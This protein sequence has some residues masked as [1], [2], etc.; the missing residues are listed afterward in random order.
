LRADL[1]RAWMIA[2]NGHKPYACGVVLH[3]A[4]DAMLDLRAQLAG[5]VDAI[6]RIEVQ[7]NPSVVAITGT[8]APTTG[9]HSKFSIYHS[10][11]VALVDG[12]A[13][14]AQYTDARAS[15]PRVTALRDRITVSVDESLQR[16]QANAQAWV[17]GRKLEARVAHASGT[18]QNPMS[19][20]AIEAKFRSNAAG[21]LSPA[22]VD[23]V[24]AD[25][26]RFDQ[27][28]EVAPFAARLEGSR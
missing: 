22:A 25:A 23:A 13:A 24:V 1:G 16:D 3:P 17:G 4:I 10:A 20:A 9:L 2:G 27:L 5:D 19:D 15:D 12:A 11:A 18:V 21:A 28:A 26:W 7:V 6:E 8:V 14:I